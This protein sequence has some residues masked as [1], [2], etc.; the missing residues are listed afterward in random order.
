MPVALL[1][2]AQDLQYTADTA[3]EH[4]VRLTVTDADGAT[5]ETGVVL[6]AGNEPPVIE[7]R[8]SN[9]NGSFYW[10]DQT[11][12]YQVVVT[13]LED[14]S[15]ED[16]SIA[17][18]DV[19]VSLDFI[20]EGLDLAGALSGHQQGSGYTNGNDLI[21]ASDCTA[22]HT[23]DKASVGPSYA[24]LAQ[25]YEGTAEQLDVLADKVLNGG[26]GNWG[27]H[28]MS[29]H[30]QH[31]R[32]EALE[33]VAAML[34]VS[35]GLQ[36]E[37]LPLAG[38]LS[39]DKHQAGASENEWIGSYN[40]GRYLLTASYTDSSGEVAA[41]Q[42]ARVSK[43]IRFPKVTASDFDTAFDVMSMPVPIEG[44]G[45]FEI[46]LF[47]AAEDLDSRAYIKLDQ[48][49]LVGIDRIR[50]GVATSK[51]FTTG[52]K[53]AVYIDSPSGELIAT[54]DVENKNIGMPDSADYYEVEIPRITGRH[55][56][57]IVADEVVDGRKAKPV[58]IF[59]L[60]E[61]IRD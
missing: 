17:A 7:I 21:E 56:V 15:T 27:E 37:G 48:L 35:S 19:M 45:E 57:Y 6:E 5:A 9:G 46:M 20:A 53:L 50:F 52:G 34:G 31:S 28:A 36:P 40:T 55:D 13:D 4:K 12:D 26:A 47:R 60:V 25:R 43:L 44:M 8:F 11:V 29:P 10:D 16:G 59:V 42:S 2:E 41:S 22:C 51:M 1:G 3:G 61:F 23:K 58:Y 54:V 33:M 39:F 49:D 32:E 30:P 38:E 24:Q 18:G 14:G